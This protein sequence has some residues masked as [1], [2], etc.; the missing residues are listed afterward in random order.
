MDKK[1]NLHRGV[2][3]V[4]PVAVY[5]LEAPKT[6]LTHTTV[7]SFSSRLSRLFFIHLLTSDHLTLST[8]Q[9]LKTKG[10]KLD[11]QAFKPQRSHATSP[12]WSRTWRSV[13]HQAD[14]RSGRYDTN[15]SGL[16]LW[17][18]VLGLLN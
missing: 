14:A 2:H 15:L 9:A 18:C 13:R 6:P 16:C 12:Q 10:L 7:Q 3:M 5:G 11:T 8:P 4:L 17:R 1:P